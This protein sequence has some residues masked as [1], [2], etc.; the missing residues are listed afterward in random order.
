[1]VGERERERER[2]KDKFIAN[3]ERGYEGKRQMGN[4]RS[5]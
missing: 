4:S 1:M 3:F 5:G 2:E